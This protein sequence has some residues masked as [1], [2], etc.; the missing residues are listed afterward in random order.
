MGLSKKMN[1]GSAGDPR[2]ANP[3]QVPTVPV[4][5][6][7]PTLLDTSDDLNTWDGPIGASQIRFNS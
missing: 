5:W 7:C 2:L 4:A 1:S 3:L 6:D